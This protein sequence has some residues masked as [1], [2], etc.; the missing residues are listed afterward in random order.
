MSGQQGE[1]LVPG[2]G[3]STPEHQHVGT[4]TSLADGREFS[5]GFASLRVGRKRRAD[6][7]ISDK[8]VSRHHADI[9]YEGGG[10][11]LYDHSRNATWVNGSLVTVA[12]QLS[13]GDAVQFGR[14]EFRFSLKD[15][16][17][18]TL[19]RALEPAVPTPIPRRSARA[20][21]AGKRWRRSGPRK[22]VRLAMVFLLL[23]FV[24]A[25]V[26]IYFIFIGAR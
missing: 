22:L 4:L 19:A 12:R 14:T 16:P 2:S 9:I 15:V 21:K 1:P 8:T 18:E 5:L 17:A 23:L 6:L 26:L 11:M 20:M 7:I 10:Y 13:N 25:A 3:R 24:A